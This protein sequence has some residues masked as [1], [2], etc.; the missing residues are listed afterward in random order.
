MASNAQRF[1][2]RQSMQNK[3]FEVFHYRDQKMEGLEVHHHD[4]YEVYLFLGG[5]VQFQVEAK[6][7]QLEP[8]DFLLIN[9]QEL[10]KPLIGQGSM[11]ERMV[12]WIDRNYLSSLCTENTDLS[13]CF[14]GQTNLLRPG[15]VRGAQLQGLLESLA[16]EYYDEQLGSAICAQG[17]L[18]QFLVELNR[19]ARKNMG[20]ALAEPDLV[21][22]VIAYI[23]NHYQENLT[24]ESLA[25]QFYVSKFY[26]SHEFRERVG[27]SIH[28]YI[29]FRRLLQARDLMAAGIG[30]GQVYQNCGFGDYANFYRAF[31]AEY[32]I[33]PREFVQGK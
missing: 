22:Q 25:G 26:L 2:S 32:G 33:S 13:A 29:I 1:D 6:T 5:Q 15:K 16:R 3:T 7:F 30:P 28:R 20:K 4:F 17:L 9:P 12:L 19:L 27:V 18:M 10:H 8:G 21:S 24:L 23:G 11:Y 31:K 14:D